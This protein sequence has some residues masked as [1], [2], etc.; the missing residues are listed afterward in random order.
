M[1]VVSYS[2]IEAMQSQGEMSE[3]KTSVPRVCF[4]NM[5]E[6]LFLDTKKSSTQRLGLTW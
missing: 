5:L 1:F 3:C 6:I 4:K 2:H